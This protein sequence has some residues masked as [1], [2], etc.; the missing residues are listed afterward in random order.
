VICCYPDM[1]KLAAAAADHAREILVLSFPTGTW[2]IRGGLFIANAMLTMA[3]REFHLFV[4]SPALIRATAESR[5][6][7]AVF[8]SPGAVW[9]V[10]ALARPPA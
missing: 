8:D 1:P 2:W 5:G 3:R 10:A 7:R 4:H 6:L 9:T